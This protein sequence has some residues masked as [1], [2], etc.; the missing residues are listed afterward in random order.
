MNTSNGKVPVYMIFF[1]LY[2]APGQFQ[3]L[4]VK[5]PGDLGCCMAYLD[6]VI[7]HS[8]VLI[9]IQSIPIATAG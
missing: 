7:V 1:G 6:D 8:L 2:N 9:S 3:A 5:V 4:M